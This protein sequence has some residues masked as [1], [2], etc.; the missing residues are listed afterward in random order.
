M[1]AVLARPVRMPRSSRRKNSAAFLDRLGGGFDQVFGLLEAQGRG[2]SND[3]DHAD[4]LVALR[5]QHHVEFGLFFLNGCIA[6][7]GSRG[8][9][10]AAAGRLDAVNF[11]QTVN[12]RLSILHGKRDQLI[13]QLG[14]LPAEFLHWCICH[15]NNS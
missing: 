14:D 15:C 5:G 6:R 3:F 9:R 13:R 1:R 11:L 4:L 8:D 10:H 12:K 7:N 2:R